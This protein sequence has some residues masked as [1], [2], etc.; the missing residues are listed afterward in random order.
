MHNWQCQEGVR[1]FA[2]AGVTVTHAVGAATV[3]LIKRPQLAL[4]VPVQWA[5]GFM[6]LIG[7]GGPAKSLSDP[8]TRN[9]EQSDRVAPAKAESMFLVKHHVKS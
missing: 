1:T 5:M 4:W 3:L 7:N 2:V 9:M 8:P 6:V